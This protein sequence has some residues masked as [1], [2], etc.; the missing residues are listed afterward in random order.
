MKVKSLSH[1]YKHRD[2]NSS[3]PSDLQFW[4]R[5]SITVEAVVEA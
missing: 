5:H 3:C 1:E 4:A 2:R